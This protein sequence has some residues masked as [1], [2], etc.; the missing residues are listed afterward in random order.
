MEMQSRLLNALPSY[1]Y[2]NLSRCRPAL[3]C[4]EM[5]IFAHDFRKLLRPLSHRQA[6]QPA[7][8]VLNRYSLLVLL[9]S[10]K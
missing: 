3:L 5:Q 4:T 6:C 2:A 7:P 10:T 1:R 8:F 9:L